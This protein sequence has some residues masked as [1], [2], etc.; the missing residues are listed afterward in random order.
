V[1]DFLFSSA[2]VF[3]TAE[4]EEIRSRADFTFAAGADHVT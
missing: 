2:W 3:Y 4:A 1:D